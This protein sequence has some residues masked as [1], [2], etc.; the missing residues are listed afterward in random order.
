MGK[1]KDSRLSSKDARGDTRPWEKTE[2]ALRGYQVQTFMDLPKLLAW[3]H[4]VT[5][6]EYRVTRQ[7]DG[8]RIMLKADNRGQAQ[9]AFTSVDFWEDALDFVTYMAET[10]TFSFK[11]DKWPAKKGKKKTVKEIIY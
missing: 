7:D 10:G 5:L 11:A 8:W 9:V 6:T 3:G 2:A 1:E 4:G